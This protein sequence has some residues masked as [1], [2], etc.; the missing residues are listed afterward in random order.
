[1]RN[2]AGERFMF[3]Y[4]R[5]AYR[6][7]I[8]ET[9]AEA[10]TWYAAPTQNRLP[11]EMLP[12]DDV[13]RAIEFEIRAGRGTARGGVLLDIA[14]RRPADVIRKG[15]PHMY[16]QFLE[17]A[18]LDI[19]KQPMEVA[20]T[21]HYL[22]GGVRIDPDSCATCVLGLYAAG[23]AAAGLHGANR[24]NGNGISELIVFGHRAGLGAAQYARSTSVDA[25]DAAQV[26]QAVAASRSSLGR[27]DGE[28][29][30]ALQRE[31]Q[32]VM[33]GQVALVRDRRGL[34]DAIERIA[35]IAVRSDRAEAPASP[36]AN[37]SWQCALDVR[38]LCAVAEAIARS[39]R[40]RE[41]TRG[42]H[43]REDFPDS[44]HALGASNVV[45]ALVGGRLEVRT[46]TRSPLPEAL[47]TLVARDAPQSA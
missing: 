26:S 2:S 16:R 8:A 6:A 31:L 42:A 27:Q 22:M 33:Q 46:E 3:R 19:T 10:D 1:M 44:D 45:C 28:D 4:V 32:D 13:S 11:P 7:Q 20:P 23:E 9:E 25:P 29:P 24:L 15:L 40:L 14:S 43:V 30:F 41:E 36:R 34:D 5:P 21:C 38:S 12:R 18:D 35:D 37:P 47:Q 17:L 39:A